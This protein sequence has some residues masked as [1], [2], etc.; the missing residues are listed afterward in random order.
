MRAFV[1]IDAENHYLR[2]TE[3]VKT[4]VKTTDPIQSFTKNI[5]P[6]H[7]MPWYPSLIQGRIY[8][9]DS[10]IQL[11]W[12]CNSLLRFGI[13]T[14][15]N[16]S[17][18]RGYYV[19]SSSGDPSLIYTQ[20]TILRSYGFDP[21]IIH[22]KKSDLNQRKNLL[23][24]YKL[25]EKP[26]GCDIMIAT[27][28]IS[29]AAANLY[30][31]CILFSSDSDFIPVI[32]TIRSMG[33]IALVFGYKSILKDKSPYLYIPDKFYDLETTIERDYRIHESEIMKNP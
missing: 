32:E 17:I 5:L 3:A 14:Q 22:E 28:I 24:Q 27:K 25:I 21:I 19:C 30:D 11:F 1:Y 12:D 33:K 16:L 2:S 18:Q 4:L 20:Q 31:V 26:K 7:D 8:S 6:I 23:N 10:A 15:Y 13:L 29:D 9:H